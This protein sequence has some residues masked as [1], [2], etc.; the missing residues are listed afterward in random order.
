MKEL[1]KKE[2]ENKQ[3]SLICSICNK[4]NLDI[5]QNNKKIKKLINGNFNKSELTEIIK[6]C[7]CNTNNNIY[8]HRYCI[9]LKIIFNFEIKCGKCNTIYNIKIDK[10]ADRNKKI[11]IFFTFLI[12]YIVHLLI[13]LF[14][15]YLL[16]INVI[17]KGSII[18]I[19][20]HLYIFFGIILFIINSILLY[21]SIINNIRK[22]KYYIFKYSINIFDVL[23]KDGNNCLINNEN[24]LYQLILEF[25]QWF[26]NQSIKDILTNI[27]KKYIFNK[28]NISYNNSIQE[29]INKNNSEIIQINDNYENKKIS[30]FQKQKNKSGKKDND[31]NS[32]DII[33]L[34]TDKKKDILNINKNNINQ[35]NNIFNNKNKNYKEDLKLNKLDCNNNSNHYYIKKLSS[36]NVDSL[37][38]KEENLKLKHKDFIN[39]NINPQNS[40]NININIHFNNDKTSQIDFSSSKDINNQSNKRKI[41]KTALIPKILMMTNIISEANSFKRKRRQLK[42]FK[43]RE[44]KIKLQGYTQSRGDIVEDEEIDFSEFDKMGTKISKV[45]KDN[46]K[47]VIYPKNDYSELKYSYFRN[48][49]S[50]KDIDL[51]ISNS[52]VGGIEG[53]SGDQN[54]RMSV[55]NMSGKHVHFA[56]EGNN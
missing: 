16:F 24:E 39:I 9:L 46:K 44:N 14:C 50:Y 8:V 13:Y 54:V 5:K 28:E 36:N 55:K 38:A 15:M 26:Y 42:S 33:A 10:I 51:N 2:N 53:S 52:D 41:G 32:K 19:Y 17:L 21:F 12:V 40:K 31:D 49:K 18:I 35:E 34:N 45:S 4:K 11:I 48:K 3:Y 47:S 43:I 1:E 37:N 56:D 22:K 20:K 30:D 7:N 27:N 25:Y 29:Y 23:T 6:K